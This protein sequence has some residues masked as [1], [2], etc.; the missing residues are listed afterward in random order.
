M[1]YKDREKLIGFIR[2]TRN[3]KLALSDIDMLRAV[4]SA[5]SFS[6]FVTARAEWVAYRQALRDYPSTIPETL[7]DDL[8][9]MPPIPLSP[10]E[11]VT[12][13]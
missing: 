7:A 11:Q 1:A 12:E 8:S 2:E 3:H 4:E 13:E 5:A 6:A 10:N 9:D